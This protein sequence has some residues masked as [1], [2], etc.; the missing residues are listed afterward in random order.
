[1]ED[2]VSALGLNRLHFARPSLLLGPRKEFRLGER[3][4]QIFM[5]LFAWVIPASYKAITGEQVARAMWVVANKDKAPKL[6][7]NGLL[8]QLGNKD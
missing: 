4:G 6:L 1:M 7:K 8:L 5:K 3:I 2:A